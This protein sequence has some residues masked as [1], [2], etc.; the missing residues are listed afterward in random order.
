MN[1][2]FW[3]AYKLLIGNLR[4][5]IFPFLGVT[6]GVIAL[7]MSLSLGAGGEKIISN[8]LLSMS[9]NRIMIGGAEMNMRDM[10]ILENYPMIQYTVFPEARTTIGRNIFRGYSQKALSTLRLNLL[11][12]REVILDKKQFTNKKIG[13]II[14]FSIDEREHTFLVKDMYEETNPFE[15]MKQGN[16]IIIS[17]EYYQR[18]FG[19]NSYSQIIM[20]FDKNEEAEEYIPYILKKINYGRGTL[21]KIKLL[22]T[23]EIYKKVI[24]IQKLVKSSLNMLSIISLCIGGFG[25]MNLVAS[26][27]KSRCNHIGIMRAIGMAKRDI[28]EIFFIEG[29]VISILGSVI[30]VAIG[31]TFSLI[32]GKLISIAPEFNFLQIAAAFFISII[33]G[34]VMG[35]YPAAKIGK[36]NIIEALKEN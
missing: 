32:F 3:F 1:M 19:K 36:M 17:Q 34:V 24:K 33:L 28:I 22:E 16:R 12:D 13:D 15:L 30:G 9:D 29:M 4:R 5:A 35:I 7:I 18:L 2:K 26:G 10:Q 6:G 8:D 20:S 31:I 23:P 27:V 14:K 11:K 21:D 25:I